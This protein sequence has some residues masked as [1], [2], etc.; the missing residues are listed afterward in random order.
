[1]AKLVKEELKESSN[2]PKK[3]YMMYTSDPDY[4][5]VAFLWMT[6]KEA[7]LKYKE[8]KNN[9]SGAVVLASVDV[10]KKENGRFY[11]SYDSM[12]SGCVKILKEHFNEE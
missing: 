4:I 5:D 7:I 10:S 8:E 11:I 12:A 1:M 2:E 3:L 9:S 6:S